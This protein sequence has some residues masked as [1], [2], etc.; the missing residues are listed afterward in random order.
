MTQLVL[1]EKATMNDPLP[2]VAAG[3]QV[4][5][6]LEN[7]RVS[8]QASVKSKTNTGPVS[9]TIAL[10]VSN[11]GILYKKDMMTFT[12]SG[13][14]SD[15]DIDFMDVPYELVRVRVT[16]LTG[17]DAEVFVTARV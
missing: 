9:A 4:P 2:V 7:P 6:R 15:T 12:L 16:A 17:A 1:L 5:W 3:V 10:D 13:T 11:D 14:G 8:I